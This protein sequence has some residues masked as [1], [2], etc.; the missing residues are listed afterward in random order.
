MECTLLERFQGGFPPQCPCAFGE[1]PQTEATPLY[2]LA[3]CLERGN[4]N[5]W[6][7]TVEE[8]GATRYQEQAEEWNPSEFL[9]CGDD[10]GTREY[11]ALKKRDAMS[12]MVFLIRV[13]KSECARTPIQ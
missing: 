5:L 6:V 4:S 9:L 12:T 11:P 3:S 2:I 13:Q 7:T 8:D 10:G 1:H